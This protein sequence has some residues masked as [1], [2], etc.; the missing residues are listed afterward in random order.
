MYIYSEFAVSNATAKLEPVAS[1]RQDISM[2]YRKTL[3]VTVGLTP[4][5]VRKTAEY[6]LSGCAV[7]A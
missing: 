7:A 3:S 4:G 2:W 6:F 1:F 5:G